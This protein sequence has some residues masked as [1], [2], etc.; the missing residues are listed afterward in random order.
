MIERNLNLEEQTRAR[1]TILAE[2]VTTEMIDG[3]TYYLVYGRVPGSFLSSV[4][5]NDFIGAIGRA[6]DNN[7]RKLREWAACM[8]NDMPSDTWGSREQVAAWIN[9]GGLV[10]REPAKA[11]GAPEPKHA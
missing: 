8:Y 2:H 7:S 4:L 9:L 3:L 1:F 6:D 5:R 10:G 11:K